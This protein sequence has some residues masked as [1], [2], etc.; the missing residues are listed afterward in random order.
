MAVDVIEYMIC[1][2]QLERSLILFYSILFILHN[3]P[4]CKHITL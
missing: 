4:P 1:D 2:F 3:C